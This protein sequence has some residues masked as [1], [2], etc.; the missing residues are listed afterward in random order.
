MSTK[1]Q[2]S[3]LSRRAFLRSSCGAALAL[4]CLESL[5]A[6]T[7]GSAMKPAQRVAFFYVPMGVV[8]EEFFPG[9]QKN[10]EQSF[11][12]SHA[13]ISTRTLSPL[14][15]MGAKVSL[16]TG[17]ART[18][19]DSADQHE[20]CGSCFLSSLAPGGSTTSRMPQ[21]R[22]LD[23]IVAEQIGTGTPFRT[24]EFNCNP[25]KDNRESIHFDTI[26]WY[27]SEYPALAMR[28]PQQIYRRL[29]TSTAAAPAQR[30]TDLVLADAKSMSGRL[31]RD[32]RD[33]LGEYVESIRSIELQMDRL[34][35][36]R[37]ELEKM[38]LP[39][40]SAAH[41]P[42]GEY[43]RL[44]GDFMVAALQSG[45]TNVATMMIA[46]E[47]WE[48]PYRFE[49]ISDKPLGHHG[50]SHRGWS[51]ELRKIDEFHVRQF[52]YLVEKMDGIL[53]ADG[54]SLLDNTI[55]TYGSGLGNGAAHSYN[56]LPIIVAGSGGGKLKTGSH[57]QCKDGTPLANLW[58]TQAQAVGGERERFADSTGVV[59]ELNV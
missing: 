38:N 35:G 32:D 52:A 16:I 43:L 56:R 26:S 27:G 36:M 15:K 46:P 11:A 48:T 49:E 28:D 6:R 24:L 10:P 47:R 51:E 4:P 50:L 39:E 13:H 20:Q 40:P 29:F 33:K 25:H 18:W 37:A 54:T 31:G 21:G 53:E 44:I 19:K 22:T 5:N 58:L 17:L 2:T 55:F 42:R 23:H 8:R 57:L 12:G 34:G 3:G 41:L 45:L 14:D 59:S 7:A 9:E 30:I 1:K